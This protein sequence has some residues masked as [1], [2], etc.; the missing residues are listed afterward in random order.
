MVLVAADIHEVGTE[1]AEVSYEL[2][3]VD[4][5][6]VLGA[7]GRVSQNQQHVML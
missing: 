6:D 7:E 2:G 5:H 3:V 4:R 1:G